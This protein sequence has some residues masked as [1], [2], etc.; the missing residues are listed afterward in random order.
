VYLQTAPL[1]NVRVV[2]LGLLDKLGEIVHC[3]S[4]SQ[5]SVCRRHSPKVN[6]NRRHSPNLLDSFFLQDPWQFCLSGQWQFNLPYI[7][8]GKFQIF[9]SV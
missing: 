4:K 3:P 7:H 8:L 1:E 9:I 5:V 6:F 2:L